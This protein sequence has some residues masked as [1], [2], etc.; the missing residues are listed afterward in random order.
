MTQ[1]G[2]LTR[3]KS[4]YTG[5]IHTLTL[6]RKLTLVPAEPSDTENAP[7]YRVHSGDGS[8]PEVGAA[9]KR[10][11]ERAGDYLSLQLDDLAFDHPIRANL[12]Q[13]D[14]DKDT[15][16]LLWN[17]PPKRGDKD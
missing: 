8:G 7:D 4:G 9:W 13:L 16:T 17:C 10:S 11:G 2:Q 15:W 3:T 6:D 1:V 14:A 5:R 12:F